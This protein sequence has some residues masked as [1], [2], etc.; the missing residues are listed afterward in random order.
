MRDFIV[1][2]ILNL[3]DKHGVPLRTKMVCGDGSLAVGGHIFAGKKL[4]LVMT[5]TVRKSAIFL[6]FG[7]LSSDG[8]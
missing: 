2:T 8:Y 5:S 6:I 7:Q 1:I 3:D 4:R